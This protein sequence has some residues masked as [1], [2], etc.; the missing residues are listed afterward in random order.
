MENAHDTSLHEMLRKVNIQLSER[1][2]ANGLKQC[3]EI[4]VSFLRLNKYKVY[5]QERLFKKSLYFNPGVNIGS[6]QVS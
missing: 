1:E 2:S 6:S 5:F 3:M 4:R